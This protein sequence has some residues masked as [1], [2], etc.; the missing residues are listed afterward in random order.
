MPPMT[1]MLRMPAA[2]PMM[3][4]TPTIAAV[5]LF[6]PWGLALVVF[7]LYLLVVNDCGVS[8]PLTPVYDLTSDTS[9]WPG[10]TGLTETKGIPKS[11]TFFSKPCNAA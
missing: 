8:K 10:S 5:F 4:R 2:V 11:R 7:I 3:N 1:T 9:A 6:V